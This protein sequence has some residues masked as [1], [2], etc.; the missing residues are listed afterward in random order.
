MSSTALAFYCPFLTIPRGGKTICAM[1][2]KVR[3]VL[4]KFVKVQITPALQDKLKGGSEGDADFIGVE[5]Y[6]DG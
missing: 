4:Q 2:I 1:K 5:D 3:K 6:V